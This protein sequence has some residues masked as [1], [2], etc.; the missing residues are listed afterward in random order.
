MKVLSFARLLALLPLTLALTQCDRIDAILKP[1]PKKPGPYAFDLILKMSPKGEAAL[2]QSP[3]GL[4]VDAWYYNT[5]APA[6]RKEADSMNRISLGTERWT[7]PN[8]VRR[9]HLRGEIVDKA[10]LSHTVDGQPNIIASVSARG[11]NP[12][13]MLTCHDYIGSVSLARQKTPVL[14]CEFD[15]EH[16]WANIP[17]EP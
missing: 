8:H 13:N 5:A 11:G 7:Y 17:A 4:F 6:Y 2:K 3:D 1:K 12:D 10:K 14:R 15:T 9:V 16:Y